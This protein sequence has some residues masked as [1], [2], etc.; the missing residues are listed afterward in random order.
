[1]RGQKLGIDGGSREQGAL[2]WERVCERMPDPGARVRDSEYAEPG[3]LLALDSIRSTLDC[4]SFSILV[5]AV[6]Q[7]LGDDALDY[8]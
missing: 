3:A 1:V 8:H 4:F 7:K 2:D 6:G 5:C